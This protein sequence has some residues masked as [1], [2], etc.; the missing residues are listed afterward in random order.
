MNR[1]PGM[2]FLEIFSVFMSLCYFGNTIFQTFSLLS[3]L[4]WSVISNYDLLK[5][6]MMVNNFNKKGIF[7]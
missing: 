5:A 1:S 4:L 2:I 3:Y 7:N 6:H